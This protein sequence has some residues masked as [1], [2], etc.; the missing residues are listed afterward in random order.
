[1]SEKRPDLPYEKA[2]EETGKAIGK[3][4]DLL[5]KA[6]PALADL[7]NFLGGDRLSEQRIRNADKYKRETKRIMEERN[8]KERRAV[9][10]ELAAPL[11]DAA[12][13]DPREE[14]Q[15]LYA[16][17]TVNAID[18]A[19][20]DHVR[21][22]F[23]ETVKKWQPIDVRV[24]KFSVGR[25]QGKPHFGAGEI[26]TAL[27]MERQNAVTVSLEHLRTLGCLSSP[28][29]KSYTATPYGAEIMRAVSE[30]PDAG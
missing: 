10:E 28:G 16:A 7:Y 26:E 8:I 21:P 19:F 1:M 6:S 12:I 5:D 11:F 27:T 18:P 24:M 29:P 14:L 30:K 17:L 23:V 3:V 20:H 4:A 15:K 13:R 22:E 2:A 9:P 25:P